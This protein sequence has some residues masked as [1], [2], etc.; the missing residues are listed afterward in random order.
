MSNGKIAPPFEIGQRVLPADLFG[1]V[2]TGL[3]GRPGEKGATRRYVKGLWVLELIARVD[4]KSTT[5]VVTIRTQS[6]DEHWW[7]EKASS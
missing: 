7:A 1:W 5:R 6:E 4:R 2:Y 3:S